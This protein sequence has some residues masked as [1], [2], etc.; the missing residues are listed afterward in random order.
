MSFLLRLNDKRE[1]KKEIGRMHTELRNLPVKEPVRTFFIPVI[2][3]TC[4]NY[5]TMVK[6]VTIQT[7]GP[8]NPPWTWNF[9][10]FVKG[11]KGPARKAEVTFPPMLQHLDSA[12]NIR[13]LLDNKFETKIECHTQSV[14]RLVALTALSCKRRRTEDTQQ[15][16]ALSTHHAQSAGPSSKRITLKNYRDYFIK[17]YWQY[18]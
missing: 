3:F 10:T 6:F 18:L 13:G 5:R 2:D 9:S 11:Y 15:R 16:L 1:Y 14:E 8:Y 4:K 12:E 17:D 7:P